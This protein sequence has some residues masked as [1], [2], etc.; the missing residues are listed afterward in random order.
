MKENIVP[1]GAGSHIAL[2]TVSVCVGCFNQEAFIDT[3]IRSVA[4]QTYTAF[5]C[6]VVDDFSTDASRRRIEEC[7]SQLGDS[8]FR[9]LPRLQNGG[10]LATMMTGLD[11]TAG[12]LISFLDGDDAWH[13]DFIECHVRAHLSH[14]RIAAMSSSDE[15]VIDTA[16][17]LLAGGHPVF[18]LND[19]RSMPK[20][21]GYLHVDTEADP[22]LLFIDRGT[23]GWFWSTTS[24]M[25]FR[26][27]PLEIMR[28]SD[29][30]EIKICAD[31]YMARAAHMIGGT[32]RIGRALGS[33]RL[34]GGNGWADGRILGTGVGLGRMSPDTEIAIRRALANRWC[35]VAP[36]LAHL[37]SRHSMRRTLVDLIGLSAAFALLEKNSDAGFLLKDWATPQRKLQTRLIGLLPPKLRPRRFRDIV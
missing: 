22:T 30:D 19:P 26:R 34:H 32:V 25:M 29:P 36:G 5:E 9:L 33:Y 15:V 17:N 27:A 23:V 20:M 13:P 2:P 4:A 24:G 8:R 3:A 7:L 21:S 28:P 35:E 14:T 18:H 1:S 37:I 12:P 31:G 11:A 10:Q 16:G 6:V